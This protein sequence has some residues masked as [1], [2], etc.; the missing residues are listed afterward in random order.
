MPFYNKDDETFYIS[1]NPAKTN[2]NIIKLGN[3]YNYMDD[4]NN[5]I[6]Q[7]IIYIYSRKEDDETNVTEINLITGETK[8]YKD[9]DNKNPSSRRQGVSIQFEN[10]TNNKTFNLNIYQHKGETLISTTKNPKN[11]N[12][13]MINKNL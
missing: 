2:K 12:I 4:I 7:T 10:E 3:P 13:K 1:F 9:T 11:N 5:N 6:H 8:T